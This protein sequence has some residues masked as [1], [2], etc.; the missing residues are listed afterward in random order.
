MTLISPTVIPLGKVLLSFAAMLLL[1]R[2]RAPL[3][4]AI[5]AGS[6]ALGLLFGLPLPDWGAAV[7]AAPFKE[8]PL[9]LTAII[10]LIM[11]LSHLLEKSGQTRRL[12]RAVAGLITSPRLR[13]AFF[14]SLIG[15][16]PMPGGAI[17]SAPLVKGAAEGLDA[18]P[19]QL[20]LVN[21][22]FRHVWEVAW[23]LYP[24]VILAASLAGLPIS[25]LIALTFPGLLLS[26]GL[27]WLLILRPGVLPLPRLVAEV[28]DKASRRDILREGLPLL[29]A[30][31][32]AVGLEMLIG[33]LWPELPFE[34]GMCAALALSIAVAL[35]QNPGGFRL[36]L[37]ALTGRAFLSM[38][39]VIVGIFGYQDVLEQSGAVARIAEL[40]G[41][42]AALALTTGLLPLLVGLVTGIT[43]AF[44]GATFPLILGMAANAGVDPLPC[45]VLGMFSGYAGVLAS[46]LHICLVLTCQYFATDMGGVWRRLVLPASVV[47]AA[48]YLYYFLLR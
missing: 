26:L 3:G 1:V 27:G 20:S 41:G 29:V 22:W 10:A 8:K 46:P 47:F 12:M 48:G 19:G 2:L 11:A 23:P 28:V 44:V 25:S 36:L 16:L 35:A 14:T 37:A 45:V 24:G 43:V 39:F 33:A 42:A 13:M 17:F 7:L 31:L 21:Y 6:L 9:F 30:I 15:L 40:T 32:G 4:A 34:A 5:L 18:T 38:L